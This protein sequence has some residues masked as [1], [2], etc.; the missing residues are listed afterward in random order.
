LF[1]SNCGNAFALFHSYKFLV[2]FLMN[3]D[4]VATLEEIK[5]KRKVSKRKRYA[6]SK[7][8]KFKFELLK[9][10]KSSASLRDLQ[11]FLAQNRTKVAPSTI[12]RWLKKNG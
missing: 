9:L 12:Q 2:V 8:D 1:F 5:K 3:F 4:A 6:K 10:H 7:L 11:F